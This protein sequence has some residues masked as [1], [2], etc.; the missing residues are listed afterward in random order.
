MVTI[1]AGQVMIGGSR[2]LTV[3]VKVQAFVFPEASIAVHVTVFTPPGNALPLA[4][5]QLTVAPGQ[6]SVTVTSK[7]TNWLH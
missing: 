4:G 7:L 1:F 5:A 6:L 2:S 3:T